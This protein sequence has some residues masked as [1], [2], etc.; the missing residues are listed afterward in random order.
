MIR[1]LGLCDLTAKGPGSIP[2]WGAKIPQAARRG[3]KKEKEDE[4]TGWW[5]QPTSQQGRDSTRFHL[6]ARPLRAAHCGR[7]G[8]M[9][10]VD[11]GGHPEVNEQLFHPHSFKPDSVTDGPNV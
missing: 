4:E 5:A 11:A 9:R 6:L 3:Q 10:A 2:G 8:S 7:A 1:W